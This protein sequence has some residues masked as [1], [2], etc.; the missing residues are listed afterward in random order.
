MYMPMFCCVPECRSGFIL[1]CRA[2]CDRNACNILAMCGFS[3]A[4]GDD[5]AD[6]LGPQQRGRRAG[7]NSL[8][9]NVARVLREAWLHV[10]QTHPSTLPCAS[11]LCYDDAPALKR[12][13]HPR[14]SA[15]MHAVLSNPVPWMQ[16]IQKGAS[17]GLLACSEVQVVLIFVS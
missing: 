5:D 6:M 7:A 4:G 13:L 1:G 15:D 9:A 10:L 2:F 11:V 14:M 12:A 16:A 8:A 17:T 3:Y